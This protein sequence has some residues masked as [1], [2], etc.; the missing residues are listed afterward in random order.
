MTLGSVS[1]SNFCFGFIVITPSSDSAVG[2]SIGDGGGWDV[3]KVT[4]CRIGLTMPFVSVFV[5]RLLTKSVWVSCSARSLCLYPISSWFDCDSIY[6]QNL[7]ILFLVSL[8]HTV[9]EKCNFMHISS[10]WGWNSFCHQRKS[11][12]M[13]PKATQWVFDFCNIINFVC[14]PKRHGWV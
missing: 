14:H 11:I 3:Q 2:R 6:D 8:D 5:T 9:T 10:L 1:L 7:S 12:M 4:F 13:L